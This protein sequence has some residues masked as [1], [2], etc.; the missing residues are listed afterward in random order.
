MRVHSL[1]L[2]INR[3]CFKVWLSKPIAMTQEHS[4][5]HTGEI[6]VDTRGIHLAQEQEKNLKIVH[7]T[8]EMP[9]KIIV[10]S[11]ERKAAVSDIVAK[12]NAEVETKS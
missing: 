9:P 3:V 4:E 1:I 12:S 2:I 11:P 6:R 5:I 7:I 10:T 8:D